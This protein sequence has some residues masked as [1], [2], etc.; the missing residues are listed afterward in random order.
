MRKNL[1]FLALILFLSLMGCDSNV[2]DSV[3]DDSSDAANIEAAQMALNDG[4]HQEAID[5]LEP[6]YDRSNPDPE[7]SR[8]LASAYMGKAGIDLTYILENASDENIG[9]F[10]VI[11]SAL[12]LG[13][14]SESLRAGSEQIAA[15]S[16]SSVS[17]RYVSYGSAAAFLE[18]LEAA[19]G[20]L[21]ALV[22]LTGSD[23]DKVQLGMASAIHFIL[24]TGCQAA[25]LRGTN[26]PIDKE[27]YREVFPADTDW[28]DL[29][30]QFADRIPPQGEI[31]VSL[32][33]DVAHVSDAVVVLMGRMG[34]DEDIAADFNDFLTDLL[35]GSAISDFDG[36][37]IADYI[38]AHLLE[39]AG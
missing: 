25:A 23:D 7:V 18:S 9:S 8:I 27:A 35:G 19:K 29:L 37:E 5:I 11:A 31:A 4:N 15:Q 21:E 38:A 10:D 16:E 20:Y 34:S 33:D 14:V 39:Y 12:S 1:L 32:Q 28:E 13:I 24:E 26:I 30:S 17:P 22:D 2:F 6:L 3:S 36:R